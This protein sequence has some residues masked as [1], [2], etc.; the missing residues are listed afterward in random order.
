MALMDRAINSAY[1][2][3]GRVAKTGDLRA[4]LQERPEAAVLPAVEPAECAAFRPRSSPTGPADLDMNFAAGV[5]T[6]TGEWSRDAVAFV[7]ARSAPRNDVVGADFAYTDEQSNRCATF[8]Q[9]TAT[10]AS[11]STVRLF[12]VPGV[13][14]KAYATV[15]LPPATGGTPPGATVALQ[16]LLGN[17]SFG[18]SRQAPAGTSA[19]EGELATSLEPLVRLAKKLV[20]ET[21]A[22]LAPV[23]VPSPTGS[24]PLPTASVPVPAPQPTAPDTPPA[25]P[26]TPEPP[27]TGQLALVAG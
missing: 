11:P 4:R 23:P 1:K 24:V 17:V 9:A 14:E 3:T 7:L 6:L 16:A 25:S 26:M 22:G 18:L 19:T 12:S 20:A 21:A 27:T 5:L 15:V 10:D 8:L 13:G 2:G